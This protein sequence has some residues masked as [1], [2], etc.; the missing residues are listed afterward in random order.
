MNKQT[1]T[2]ILLALVT[3]TGCGQT[4]KMNDPSFSDYLPLLNIKGYKAYSFDTSAFKG[5]WAELV[6]KEYVNG[7]IITNSMS[8]YGIALGIKDKLIMGFAPSDNDST[9][10]FS[11]HCSDNGAFSCQL[12]LKPIVDPNNSGKKEFQYETRPFELVEPFSVGQFI[13]LVLYGSWW[14]DADI[15]GTRF[16]GENF[17]KP[18]LSSDIVQFIPHY[19]VLGIKIK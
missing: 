1:F 11:F 18:D 4:I 17:I 5:K 3:M 19:F 7:E 10:I 14:Y 2:T 9:T 15:P 8:D 13:P 12:P 16:C 6:V